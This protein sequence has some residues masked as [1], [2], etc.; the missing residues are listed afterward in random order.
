MLLV[1]EEKEV[2]KSESSVLCRRCPEKANTKETESTGPESP[3]MLWR[4]SFLSLSR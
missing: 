1:N 2:V 3:E 4:Q